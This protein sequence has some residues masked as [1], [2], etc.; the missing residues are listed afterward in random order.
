MSRK[1]FKNNLRSL[2]KAT[3]DLGRLSIAIGEADVN[4][5]DLT[6]RNL[7]GILNKVRHNH[8]VRIDA[9][10]KNTRNNS[11]VKVRIRECGIAQAKAE[12]KSWCDV[13]RV[14]PSVYLVSQRSFQIVEDSPVINVGPF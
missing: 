7:S 12:F 10:C 8:S 11:G 6:A 3:Q 2:V 4:L 5:T 13:V 1:L 9:S 14:E